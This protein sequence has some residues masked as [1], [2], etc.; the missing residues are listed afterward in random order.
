MAP[1]GIFCI[2]QW[3]PVLLGR[4]IPGILRPLKPTTPPACTGYETINRLKP[5]WYSDQFPFSSSC[6]PPGPSPGENHSR[7]QGRTVGSPCGIAANGRFA[8]TTHPS[9]SRGQDRHGRE[10]PSKHPRFLP[11]TTW[12][13]CGQ[14]RP[15]PP[16]AAESRRVGRRDRRV[17]RPRRPRP[18]DPRIYRASLAALVDALGPAHAE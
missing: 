14:C 1:R 11:S 2:R 13:R 10:R 16:S 17:P 5:D 12:G 8:A 3:S 7:L 15:T 4:W 18:D 6:N 9:R